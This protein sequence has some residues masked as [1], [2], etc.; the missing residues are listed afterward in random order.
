MKLIALL[1]DSYREA[2]DRKIFLAMLIL[3]GLLTV[4]IASI[5]FRRIT[6]EDELRTVAGQLAWG[7]SFDPTMGK[8]TFDVENFRQTNDAAEP[9]HGDYGF[10]WVVRAKDSDTLKRLP[11]AKRGDVRQLIRQGFNYLTNVEVSKNL[12]KDP[13]E[14]RFTVTSR[15]TTV[16]DP[17]AWRYEP[18][19]LF[20]VPLPF[21]H[22]SMSEAVYVIENTLVSG[23]G[24]WVAVLVGVIVTASFIPDLLRK[25]AIDLILA[26]PIR[27]AGLLLYKYIGGLAFVF[28]LTAVTVLC[29]WAAIGL[30]SGIW[31]PG[32][33][34]VIPAVTFYF[35]LLYSVSTLTAVLTRSTVVSILMTCAVWF[36]FWL[37]GTVHSTLDGIRKTKGE[38]EARIRDLAGAPPAAEKPN[39]ADDEGHSPASKMDVPRWVYAASDIVYKVLPRTGDLN[40]LTAVWISRGL[41]TEP[42]IKARH[43]DTSANLAWGETVAVTGAFIAVMLTLACWK[44]ART[45]Y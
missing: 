20:A 18:T 41:L 16:E 25:G 19:I 40:R 21:L 29:V 45:D 35:A 17:L 44:F 1:K 34:L 7:M 8:P 31:S 28:L 3:T 27:R 32:F 4:F 30:R 15:G 26:K 38:A 9:W 5:S 6:V 39:D 11:M 23:V 36:V 33:L 42:Q 2:I 22:T 14:A 10:D 24:A 43:L 13:K 12:S 37:N